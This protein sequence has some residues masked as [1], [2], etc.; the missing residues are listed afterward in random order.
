MS[1]DRVRTL[2]HRWRASGAL[3]DERAWILARARAG[4]LPADRLELAQALG[5]EALGGPEHPP[6]GF[7]EWLDALPFRRGRR[8]IERD[9]LRVGLAITHALEPC[10][11]VLGVGEVYTQGQAAAEASLF[12]LADDRRALEALFEWR[13]ERDWWSFSTPEGAMAKLLEEV[14]VDPFPRTMGEFEPLLRRALYP[15]GTPDPVVEAVIEAVVPASGGRLWRIREAIRD[16]L[17]PWVLGWGDPLWDRVSARDEG[18]LSP[19]P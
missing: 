10:A 16:E 12:G 18:D 8:R 14:L 19:E 4:L 15:L 9:S 7:Q 17:L 6:L 5:A 13:A 11:R 2:E 3:E 1:D